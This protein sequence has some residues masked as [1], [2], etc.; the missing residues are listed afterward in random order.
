[1][2]CV[3]LALTLLCCAVAVTNGQSKSSPPTKQ[4]PSS[5]TL[6]IPSASKS[7]FCVIVYD[8]AGKPLA[9]G[10]GFF[11]DKK[12]KLVTNFHVIEGA[13]T[14]V[15]K[16]SNG[17]FYPVEG[18]LGVDKTNDLAVLK[19]S[20][21]DFTFL[22]LGDSDAVQVGDKVLAIGSPLGLEDTISDGLISAIRDMGD[23]SVFQTTAAISPGSSGGVLLNSKGEAIGIT[24]FQLV[25]GQSLNFAVPIKYVRPLLKSDQVI[26][27]APIEKIPAEQPKPPARIGPPPS[28]LPRDWTNLQD[29]S[30]VSVRVDGEFVYEQ[31]KVL[32]DGKYIKEG[33]YIC[34]M[35]REGDR[36]V[37]KC[38]YRVLLL[39]AS[40]IVQNWCT[41]ELDETITSITRSRIEGES[42][43]ARP[44]TDDKTC[45]SPGT[46]KSHFALIPKY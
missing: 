8:K 39:W 37:G 26:A 18:I 4:N 38:R 31:G 11:V 15:A 17:A 1:M 45:A 13:A 40:A 33:T 36:W 43:E 3:T 34:E 30:A 42:Q 27:F 12:G 46:T 19:V 44:A 2:K 25:S 24:S 16:A 29:G 35:K 32:G 14:A 9:Q 7:V 5:N 22:P 41:V 21:S 23:V 6:N 20:G 10:S 28:D